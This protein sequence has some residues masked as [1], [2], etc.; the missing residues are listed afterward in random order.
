MTPR[1]IVIVGASVAGVA[2]A[3]ELRRLGYEGAVTL[4]GD[5][6]HLPYDRP[7]LSKDLLT[8]RTGPDRIL[9]REPGHYADR[10]IDLVLG[11][12][13]VG[14]RGT[15][16]ALSDGRVLA[17]GAVVIATG[18]RARPL[19]E[20]RPTLVTLRGLDDG[21]HL[22]RRLADAPRLVIAGGGF[23]GAEVAASARALG[24]DVTL[25]EAAPLPFA[26]LLGGQV[27]AALLR[28]HRDAGVRVLT[29]APV[30]RV[31]HVDGSERV[32]L[33]DGR[34]VHGDLVL[35][36][37]GSLP[38]TGWLDGSGL[39]IGD[40]VLCDATGATGVPGVYAVGDVA[41]WYEPEA[42]RHVRHEHW[43]GATEQARSV[44]ARI[45]GREPKA[46]PG[47]GVPYLWSDQ[48][49]SRIQALGRPEVADEIQVVRGSLEA[50]SFAVLYGREGRL[51]GAAGRDAAAHVMRHR[52]AIATAE[53][54]PLQPAAGA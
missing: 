10:G 25:I 18:A 23:I 15:H 12:P 54:M 1:E 32:H 20:P 5:E 26:H 9:L 2:V 53:P 49:G 35:A 28:P 3:D 7:P 27:A 47:A 30:Q 37:I 14:L 6:P 51:V 48:Y 41:A 4:V 44:A 16:V 11:V 42:G 52:Q 17:P 40:G 43:T 24:V 50:D 38:N 34:V 13:A 8:G 46:A 33:P 31:D 45:L 29:G 39:S 19:G 22:R 36:G 21:L